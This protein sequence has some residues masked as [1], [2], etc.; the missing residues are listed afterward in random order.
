M[1]LPKIA[2]L[3]STVVAAVQ[4]C[5]QPACREFSALIQDPDC[6]G[7]FNQTF[8]APGYVHSKILATTVGG[9]WIAP[10]GFYSECYGG[11]TCCTPIDNDSDPEA[12]LSTC[13]GETIQKLVI[14]IH[15]GLCRED[16]CDPEIMY[17]LCRDFSACRVAI[18]DTFGTA[19]GLRMEH[20][21]AKGIGVVVVVLMLLALAGCCCAA[22]GAW[23]GIRCYLKRRRGTA[24]EE[25]AQLAP[26]STAASG[27]GSGAAATAASVE[28]G[29]LEEQ[30]DVDAIARIEAL[31]GLKRLLDSGI[32]TED[33]WAEKKAQML[34]H[35]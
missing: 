11:N 18:S 31:E 2:A 9:S 10:P 32:L 34:A 14:G 25:R 16:Y 26:R 4:P 22:I 19:A 15:D 23:I 35:L 7:A 1:R 5:V 30:S 17:M 13:P 12:G 3:A 21:C 28:L 33:E 20:G 8:C 6:C 27:A 29:Q 24:V